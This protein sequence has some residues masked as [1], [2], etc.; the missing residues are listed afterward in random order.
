MYYVKIISGFDLGRNIITSK[1]CEF[2]IDKFPAEKNQCIRILWVAEPNEVSHLRTSVIKNCKDF[3]LVLTHDP[4]ILKACFNSRVY[5]FG[6]TWI[7]DFDF[8]QEKEY[9]ITSLIGAK[10][11]LFNHTL[12]QQLPKISKDITSIPLHLWNSKNQPWI[13]TDRTIKDTTYKN[14]LFYSQFHIA[15]ENVTSDN[16]FTEK[17]VDCFQTKTVPIYIGCPNLSS[18]F[19]MKG[20]FHIKNLE[21]LTNIC[22]KITPDTYKSMLGAVEENYKLSMPYANF[23]ETLNKIIV[24]FVDSSSKYS[25]INNKS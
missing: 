3:D 9:C 8:N 18:F 7:K 5:P 12:R 24:E 23:R 19:N 16:Y 14:E 17:L 21:E 15:I 13:L 22:N 10:S 20:I 6:T 1:P 4:E 25:Y 11:F 2:Y